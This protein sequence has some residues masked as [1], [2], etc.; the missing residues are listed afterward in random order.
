[1]S[2]VVKSG[3][4]YDFGPATSSPESLSEQLSIVISGL[5]GPHLVCFFIQ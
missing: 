4:P 3:H 1:M 2:R 5:N